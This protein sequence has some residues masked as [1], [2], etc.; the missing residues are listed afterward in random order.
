MQNEGVV[1]ISGMDGALLQD[2]ELASSDDEC[3]G[4]VPEM[5]QRSSDNSDDC[6][7]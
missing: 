2:Q 1:L 6:M 3:A 4:V 7:T 5:T